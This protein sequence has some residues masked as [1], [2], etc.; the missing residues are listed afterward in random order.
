MIFPC[1]LATLASYPAYQ[2]TRF[3][4]I[5]LSDVEIPLAPIPTLS[6]LKIMGIPFCAIFPGSDWT[7]APGHLGF[8]FRFAL[9]ELLRLAC[10][11]E[12]K[13]N[14]A[15]FQLRPREIGDTGDALLASKFP[16]LLW[17]PCC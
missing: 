3:P 15:G 6:P 9:S 8:R 14:H 16:P 7:E 12:A 5:R 13:A 1:S 4:G 10:L 11:P 2:D 17:P